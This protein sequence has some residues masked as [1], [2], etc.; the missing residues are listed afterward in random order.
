MA[1]VVPIVSRYDH[2]VEAH[3]RNQRNRTNVALYV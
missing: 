3:L 2:G 1:D